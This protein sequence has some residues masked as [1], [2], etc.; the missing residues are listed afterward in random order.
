MAA[1]VKSLNID[2]LTGLVNLYP[3]FGLARKELCARMA[4]ISGSNWG[5]EQFA[6]AALYV[7]SREKIFNIFRDSHKAD[8]SDKDALTLVKA[9][10]ETPKAEEGGYKRTVRVVGDRKSVV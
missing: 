7:V 2:E 5:E 8:Y 1:D 9:Y 6:D 10:V 4:A 3:W